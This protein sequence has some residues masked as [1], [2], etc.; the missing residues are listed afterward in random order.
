MKPISMPRRCALKAGP[1]QSRGSGI[2]IQRK[3]T[4]NICGGDNG[5]PI[6]HESGGRVNGWRCVMRVCML[7]DDMLCGGFLFVVGSKGDKLWTARKPG[8]F[9]CSLCS[10]YDTTETPQGE[11]PRDQSSFPAPSPV[12]QTVSRQ[13]D[14][15]L[16]L[17]QS[18]DGPRSQQWLS[19]S[20]SAKGVKRDV[21]F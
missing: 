19:R 3:G 14:Y 9:R 1:A 4:E 10:T 2:A 15:L 20:S 11:R 7:Y 13:R 12:A 21:V 5:I 6:E 8:P 17:R 18:S 16:F